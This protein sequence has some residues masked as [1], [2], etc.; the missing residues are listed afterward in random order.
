MSEALFPVSRAGCS[1]PRRAFT[2]IELM[3]VIAIIAILAALLLPTL[4]KA[5]V[6]GKSV[7]CINNL[8]Q[9][10][11]GWLMYA[12]D[13]NDNL[14]AN[15]WR[16]DNWQN[17]CPEGGQ[18]T[19]DSWVWGD[20]TQDRDTWNIKNGSLFPYINAVSTYH[21]PADKSTLYWSRKIPRKRS[22]SLSFYM[23][24]KEVYPQV[25]SKL[26][27]IREPAKVFA[28]LDE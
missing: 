21:C 1:S 11:M 12:H 15:K 27:Q 26:C 5:K 23:N 17:D 18:V 9:L 7:D 16:N 19:A 2:L 24:G 25:K 13:H 4:A 10:Q 22:Y 14:P 28:F 6:A 20:T 8:K 3:V